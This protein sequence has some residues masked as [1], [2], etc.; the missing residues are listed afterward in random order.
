MKPEISIHMLAILRSTINM[1][2]MV[3]K[4]GPKLDNSHSIS[5]EG[6]RAR[7][8]P[9]GWMEQQSSPESKDAVDCRTC[10]RLFMTFN[11]SVQTKQRVRGRSIRPF[12]ISAALVGASAPQV[13]PLRCLFGRKLGVTRV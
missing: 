4:L 10:R 13:F 11:L 8:G 1:Q 6:L 12:F 7:S 3:P 5:R 2:K 9:L